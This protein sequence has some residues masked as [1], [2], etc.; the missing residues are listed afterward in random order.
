V[1]RYDLPRA[2]PEPLRL[3][4]RIVNTIDREH[5]HEWLCSAE[6]LAALLGCDVSQADV[7][8]ARS[9]R[10]ALRQL[11]LAN[12]GEPLEVDAVATF[13]A[14]AGALATLGGMLLFWRRKRTG[15]SDE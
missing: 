14:A 10:E 6:D 1:P 2:A 3:V 13:N 5:G 8:R 11:L 15:P 7:E 9:L 12:N 4:Q